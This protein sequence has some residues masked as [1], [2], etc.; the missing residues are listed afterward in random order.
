MKRSI[1]AVG[2]ALV[3]IAVA[4]AHSGNASSYQDYNTKT[5]TAQDVAYSNVEKEVYDVCNHARQTL[6]GQDEQNCGIAQDATG[7]EFL[8]QQNTTAPTDKCGVEVE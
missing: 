3:V 7:T 1:P 4:I 5:V 6:N 8:C 2:V